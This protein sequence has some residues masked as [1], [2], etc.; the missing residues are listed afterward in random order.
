MSA[1][2]LNIVS[3]DIRLRFQVRYGYMCRFKTLYRFIIFRCIDEKH[4]E[5]NRGE[6]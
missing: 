2:F 6:R 4:S 1:S 5:E 3:R